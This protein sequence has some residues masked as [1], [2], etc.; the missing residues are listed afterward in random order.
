MSKQNTVP[1]SEYNFYFIKKS[2]PLW[3]HWLLFPCFCSF[4][5]YRE[6]IIPI[7]PLPKFPRGAICLTFQHVYYYSF[8][9]MRLRCFH[10]FIIV[11]YNRRSCRYL[12]LEL[13]FWNEFAVIYFFQSKFLNLDDISF[14]EK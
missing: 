1:V 7:C 13:K 10:P 11:F 6:Q 3:L 2:S 4:S 12:F 14:A 8:Q 9:Q 5:P